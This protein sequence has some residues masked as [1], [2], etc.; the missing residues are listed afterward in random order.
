MKTIYNKIINR[1]IGK[2]RIDKLLLVV[3]FLVLGFLIPYT[4]G[5]L[6]NYLF[7]SSKYEPIMLTW[8]MGVMFIF[9][10]GI[11]I[12]LFILSIH[13]FWIWITT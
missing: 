3:L 11:A 2:I 10:A 9:V 4:S 13:Q 8:C 12:L 6:S 1:R 5:K 7:Y